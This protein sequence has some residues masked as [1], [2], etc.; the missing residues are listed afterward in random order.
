VSCNELPADR[1]PTSTPKPVWLPETAG[2]PAVVWFDS[3]CDIW[4]A[5][6]SSWFCACG[7]MVSRI[8]R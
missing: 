6:S 7:R 3:A 5:I 8:R 2:V 4:L 1:L